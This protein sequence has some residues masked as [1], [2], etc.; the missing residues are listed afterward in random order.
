MHEECS[1]PLRDVEICCMKKKVLSNH[2]SHCTKRFSSCSSFSRP[3]TEPIE[4]P[5]TDR[6]SFRAEFIPA[7]FEGPRRIPRDVDKSSI[8]PS[9]YTKY[10]VLQVAAGL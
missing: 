7:K 3:G 10:G 8:Y 5:D 2:N 6:S 1:G 4:T 9:I